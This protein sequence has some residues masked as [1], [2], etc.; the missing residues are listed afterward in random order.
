M[1]RYINI[2]LLLMCGLALE[3]MNA[4]R[5]KQSAVALESKKPDIEPP[6]MPK[7]NIL[8]EVETGQKIGAIKVKITELEGKIEKLKL[9]IEP[10]TK[11]T[12]D[13]SLRRPSLPPYH[14]DKELRD[15]QEELKTLQQELK[16][17]QQ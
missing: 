2:G 13:E 17:L 1:F 16:N 14:L 15:K 12:T 8:E 3:A 11:G 9:E 4:L 7:K 5:N 10:Y 6:N